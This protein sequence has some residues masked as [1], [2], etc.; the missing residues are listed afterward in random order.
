MAKKSIGMK[1]L[2]VVISLIIALALISVATTTFWGF[3]LISKISFEILWLEYI[4]AGIVGI[5]GILGLISLLIQTFL[6]K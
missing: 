6:K 2:N 1:I 5:V 4:I 3:N